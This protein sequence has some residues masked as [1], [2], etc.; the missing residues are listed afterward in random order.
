MVETDIGKNAKRLE[1]KSADYAAMQTYMDDVAD[2][3]EG[4][5]AIKQAGERYLPKYPDELQEEY[6]FR[7]SVAMFTNI[8]RDVAEGLAAKPFEMPITFVDADKVATEYTDFAKNV[9][10]SGRSM[11]AFSMDLF[12][13]AIT[14]SL[15]WLFVDFSE[16]APSPIPRTKAQ[17]KAEGVRPLWSRISARNMYEVRSD[18]IG[19]RETLTYARFFEPSKGVKDKGFREFEVIDGVATWIIWRWNT[20]AKDYEVESSGVF[21]IGEIPII[22]MFTGRRKGMTFQSY[23]PLKDAKQLQ[24]VLYRAESNLEVTKAFAAYPMKVG[25]GVTPERDPSG[26][27]KKIVAGPGVALYAP[28]TGAGSA[29][30]WKYLEPAGTSLTFLRDDVKEKKQ[31]IR[32]LGK[33]PLTVSSGNLTVITTAVA[34]GKSKS[35]VKAWAELLNNVLDSAYRLTAKWLSDEVNAPKVKVFVEF[36]EFIEPG[37][38]IQALITMQQNG[39]LSDETCWEE[40]QRR[41]VLSANFDP[42]KERERLL[43]QVPNETVLNDPENQPPT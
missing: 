20:N 38:D 27:I 17:D 29:T 13:Y 34:A 19:G 31:D 12:F 24:L 14:Q 25:V 18:V 42:K 36:D 6:D 26:K 8:W 43:A 39:L 23:P 35:A 4:E 2:I 32:E 7:L 3:L 30:D 11:T 33:Q 1:A 15:D 28:F 41:R 37:Q 40:M 21:P 10:G 22:P 16:V 5:E 9:D